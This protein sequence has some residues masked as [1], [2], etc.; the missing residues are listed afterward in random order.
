MSGTVGEPYLSATAKDVVGAVRLGR[1]A[2]YLHEWADREGIDPPRWREIVHA[3]CE[4]DGISCEFVVL[5][6]DKDLTVVYN[7]DS[8]PSFDAV[9][10]SVD[11]MLEKRWK[12]TRIPTELEYRT[13]SPGP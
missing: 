12:N 13:R 10:S 11:A 3:A 6:K 8:P 9:R 5:G 1:W 2:V 4:E 7:A